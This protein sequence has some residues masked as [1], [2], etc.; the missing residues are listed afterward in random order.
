MENYANFKGRAR[1]HEFWMFI[2]ANLIISAICPVFA[3]LGRIYL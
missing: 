1:R 2:L 3:F